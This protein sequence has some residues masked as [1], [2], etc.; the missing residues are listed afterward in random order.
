MGETEGSCGRIGKALHFTTIVTR[1]AMLGRA[2]RCTGRGKEGSKGGER[3]EIHKGRNEEQRLKVPKLKC[4]GN[5]KTQDRG[6]ARREKTEAR[7]EGKSNDSL[8]GS[9]FLLPAP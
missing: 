6:K 1:V 4:C 8:D 2:G 3:G 5:L 9:T 7:H